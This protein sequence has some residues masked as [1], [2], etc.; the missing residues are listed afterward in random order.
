[1]TLW[2][3]QRDR[4]IPKK[5]SRKK[6]HSTHQ[7]EDDGIGANEFVLGK[8]DDRNCSPYASVDTGV[9]LPTISPI[10]LLRVVA[11]EILT[12]VDPMWSTHLTSFK[13]CRD[14]ETNKLESSISFSWFSDRHLADLD[15]CRTNFEGR[16]IEIWRDHLVKTLLLEVQ[17]MKIEAKPKDLST[18]KRKPSLNSEKF[19]SMS[20][21]EF[22]EA[23]SRF[24]KNSLE[25]WPDNPP[26]QWAVFLMFEGISRFSKMIALTD[27][28]SLADNALLAEAIDLFLYPSITIRLEPIQFP[29]GPSANQRTWET[30]FTDLPLFSQESKASIADSINLIIQNKTAVRAIVSLTI[31]FDPRSQKTSVTTIYACNNFSATLLTQLHELIQQ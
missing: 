27:F 4:Q 29:N 2:F 14:A 12:S 22:D 31:L 13:V 15:A 1:M 17:N 25:G 5:T 24:E 6:I 21:E 8:F 10:E 28:N 3:L 20:D 23:L 18:I 19:L 26:L 16:L 7:I 9:T 11:N 30:V